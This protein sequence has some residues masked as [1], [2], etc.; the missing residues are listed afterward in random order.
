M[1]KLLALI[2]LLALCAALF[3]GCG[4]PKTGEKVTLRFTTWTAG[5][6]AAELQ[7][8]L[9]DINSKN[10]DFQIIHE[11]SP[12]DYQTKLMTTLSGGS[13]AD[14]MW[15]DQAVVPGLAAKGAILDISDYLK[16]DKE[17]A[18][19]KID[20]YFPKILQIANYQ[21]KYFGLPWVAQPIMLY[22][23]PKMFAAAGVQPPTADWTWKEFLAA[24]AKL[25]IPGQ[26]WGFIINTDNWPPQAIFVWQAGG[27][28]MDV[29]SKTCPIDSPQALEAF[30]YYYGMYGDN[31]HCPPA[32]TIK[33][34]GNEQMFRNGKVAMF[35]GGAAD[36]HAQDGNLDNKLFTPLIAPL[37]K[38]PSGKS[39]TFGWSAITAINA[40]TANP[41]IAY[42]AFIQLT[43]AIHHWKV[44]A[45]R[46]SLATVE[47]IIKA[48]HKTQAD[49]EQIMLVLNDMRCFNNILRQSEWDDVWYK[50][51]L[52]PMRTNP[53]DIAA[54][55]KKVRP[56]LESF[57]K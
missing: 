51:V 10:T 16:N 33:E 57:L 23:N 15:L 41:A 8:I 1:K 4:G 39:V 5:E 18:A 35:M 45:P 9:D 42:K 31:K 28:I 37:P 44:V 32:S 11:P 24:S 3:A 14:L 52:E 26:Q 56:R 40:K 21:D 38:G 7:K 2:A 36:N 53:K 50:E 54:I 20:D 25:T 43:D 34:Q 29:A 46:K 47:N 55:A 27:E 13:G 30:N 22:Y 12:A 17:N 49:A 19:A 6:E 48:P